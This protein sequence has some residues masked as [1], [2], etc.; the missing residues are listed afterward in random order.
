MATLGC[1]V[2]SL[3]G[4]NITP[5]WNYEYDRASHYTIGRPHPVVARGHSSPHSSRPSLLTLGP[6]PSKPQTVGAGK[7]SCVRLMVVM[8]S[9]KFD[10]TFKK[11]LYLWEFCCPLY[12]LNFW[13]MGGCKLRAVCWAQSPA[14]T[15]RWFHC[16]SVATLPSSPPGFVWPVACWVHK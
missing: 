2:S 3:V 10:D 14:F 15:S 1:V 6:Q 16:L 7:C 12:A 8:T 4:G 5:G 9:D 13:V 11:H